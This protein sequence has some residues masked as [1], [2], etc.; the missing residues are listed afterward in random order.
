MKRNNTLW[1]PIPTAEL[2]W[3]ENSGPRSR[4][5]D[6][7]YFSTEGGLD[8]SEY[9]FLHG[10][11]LPERWDKHDRDLFC[12]IET[13]FGTGLNFLATWNLWRQ[14]KADRPR[15]HYIS[16]EKYP[17]KKADLAR[18]L[19]NWP[20]LKHLAAQLEE[21]YPVPI[22]GQHRLTLEGGSVI[23]DLWWED[24]DNALADL[25][26]GEQRIADAWYLDGFSP[27]RNEDM[28]SEQLYSTMAAASRP[29]ATFSTFTAAGDVRRGLSK[30]GFSVTKNRGFGRK[31][32]CLKGIAERPTPALDVHQ[33]PWDLKL[34]PYKTTNS[35]VVLGAGL[36]G[37]TIANALAQRNINV[38]LIEAEQVASGGSRNSQGILYTRLST[39]HS[40]LT[41]FAL[42][43]F[44]FS[45]HFYKHLLKTGVLIE[46][47]DGSLCGSFHQHKST[48]EMS[49]LEAVL[50]RAPELAQVLDAAE[51][52]RLTGVKQQSA[53]YWFPRS[54]WMHP[55]SVCNALIKHPR[56]TLIENA[57]DA[58][59]R[60]CEEGWQATIDQ[61]S[62]YSAD[63]A[64]IATGTSAPKHPALA[65]LP[66]QFIR[67][68][69]T[70][71]ATSELFRELK[72]GLCHSGYISPAR[73]GSHCI[74]ATFDLKDEDPSVRV[75]DHQR[76]LD[77]LA[78]AIPEWKSTLADIDPKSLDGK[79]AYRFA[80]P[81]FLPMV[82]AVP[83]RDAFLHTY[84]GLR[85]N[86]KAIVAEQGNYMPGLFVSVGHGSRG[87]TSTPLAAQ[88]LASE[89]CAEAPPV[90]RELKRALSPSRFL[91]R[92]LKRGAP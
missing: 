51:A 28:W 63:C 49:T 79:V 59:L 86:A 40:P 45:H 88:M 19:L 70:E 27:A 65:W 12:I 33:T 83:D 32:E 17:L 69:T 30:A 92:D 78:Q 76:N 10:N 11:G 24:V 60:S 52:S 89:I 35:V 7:V 50:T 55:A 6:D 23:L 47:V 57:G 14:L 42:Q 15:L 20:T 58:Q 31:R 74:G 22:Y 1:S 53:G 44:C 25:A 61:G 75:A 2:V 64:V 37:C 67:G 71:I 87:L 54:G 62:I 68:Q 66:G 84:S 41:D 38:T 3:P 13:G 18:A 72:T 91:I 56:I 36:A 77:A 80:T 82:G 26:R 43:S 39:K 73:Q 29:K 5:Y 46:D 90:S 8:E 48:R 16:V 34:H 81:D 85:K 9:V 4:L 21:S